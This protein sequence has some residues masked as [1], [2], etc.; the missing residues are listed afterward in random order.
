MET[1]QPTSLLSC[2]GILVRFK[3]TTFVLPWHLFVCSVS[4]CKSHHSFDLLRQNLCEQVGWY[5]LPPCGSP[6]P[7]TPL[8]ETQPVANNP[9]SEFTLLWGVCLQCWILLRPGSQESEEEEATEAFLWCKKG[10]DA[11]KIE[12]APSLIWPGDDSSIPGTGCDDLR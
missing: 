1:G 8:P 7:W 6:R 11:L 12:E 4:M 9:K 10:L 2:H 3:K 5:N